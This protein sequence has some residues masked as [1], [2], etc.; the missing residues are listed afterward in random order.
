MNE[1]I[2]R[3]LKFLFKINNNVLDNQNIVNKTGQIMQRCDKFS[4]RE[5]KQHL[6]QIKNCESKPSFSTLC[7]LIFKVNLKEEEC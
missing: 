1:Y 3:R 6:G 4:N 7:E 5:N 2:I